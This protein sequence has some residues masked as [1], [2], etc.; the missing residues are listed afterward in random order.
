MT[1]L[2]ITALIYGAYYCLFAS[3]SSASTSRN[4]LLAF[5]MSC[6]QIVMTELGLGL[7]HHLQ[8]SF[9]LMI[10][11]LIAGLVL[12]VAHR[13]RTCSLPFLLKST[14]ASCRRSLSAA[15]DAYTVSL[16]ILVILVYGWVVASAYYLPPRGIDDLVYH[17]PTIFE[18]IQSH[19][20]RLLPV[21]LR[22]QYAFPEN[23][24]LLFL[25]PTI[26]TGNQ[27][28][29][30]GVN[31]P[32]VFFSILTVYALLRH[33][34]IDER[35]ALFA[36]LLYA[37]CPVVM[38]QSG[39]NYID[40]IVSLF[41]LLGLYFSL[42]FHA[43]GSI[44]CLY[45]AGV[46]T[47]LMLG[48]KYTAL[49]LALPLQL[50]ILPGLF[51]TR[52]RHTAGY[53]GVILLLCGWW[54]GRNMAVFRDPFYPL[55]FLGFLLGKPGG[56]GIFN[57]I[58]VNLSHW[59]SQ[60]LVGD[61]G[62]GSCDGGF[63]LVFWGMGFSSWLY[64]GIYSLV[65]A[66]KTGMGRLVSL[67]YLPIGFLLL[68][69]VQDA[70]VPYM[71]RLAIFVVA[72]GLFSFCETMKILGDR[73]CGAILKGTCIILSLLSASLLAVSIKPHFNLGTVIQ[74]RIRQQYPPDFKYF[75][76]A[77][78]TARA[79]QGFVCEALD[80]ITR[81]DKT[82]LY[83]HLISDPYLFYPSSAY[84]SNL[85]NRLAYAHPPGRDAIEAYVH[86]YYPGLR[87]MA[88]DASTNS[89]DIIADSGYV[90]AAHWDYGCLILRRDIF[91]KP[92]KQRLLA[93]YYRKT[94]PEAITAARQVSP[95]LTEEI[96]I[97]TSSQIGY[98]LRFL[99]RGQERMGRVVTVPGTLESLAAAG[100]KIGRCY[101]F[102]KPLPG[103]NADKV[104]RVA[105]ANDELTV[106]L[107]RKP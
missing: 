22:Y 43:S 1:C 39:V 106:Y 74:D 3:S 98:G 50:L 97:V 107:N 102:G 52:W 48:M 29:V 41:C 81:D 46:S 89:Y 96:P 23:A 51:R 47:G 105:Y 59:V 83:C 95:V 56:M 69:S 62:I 78:R 79:H 68:L 32:F 65:H 9:L 71:G 45:A 82:G 64:Y 11:V 84:G 101:T 17:L 54:Y 92:E 53:L 4:L 2:A 91:E 40:L 61:I 76:P 14:V 27:R 100:Q 72:I 86:T 31:V 58:R 99:Y 70:E 33:F 94:W 42:R 67:A 18:Y 21:T 49:L 28:M 63:G 44:A 7:G 36:S 38:M 73:W 25:W 5:V 15:G 30:D 88:V 93:E 26:F 6:A 8:A 13:R 34:D 57:N 60:Q 20:I 103:F 12:L 104:G 90:V 16:G 19:E 87:N 35:D 37:L 80:Y 77:K 85:Q 75:S 66:G 24:E 55:N 10:N